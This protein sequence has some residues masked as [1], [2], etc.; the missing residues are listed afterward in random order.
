MG[1]LSTA[2][3]EHTSDKE[4]TDFEKYDSSRQPFVNKNFGCSYTIANHDI[5]LMATILNSHSLLNV[6]LISNRM[7][8]FVL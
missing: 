4:N 7:F 6:I 8:D 5:C 1:Q 2:S 3:T